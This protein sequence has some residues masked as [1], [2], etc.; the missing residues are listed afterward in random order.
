MERKFSIPQE[1]CRAISAAA[2]V[3]CSGSPER[4]KH[5]K[6][7]DWPRGVMLGWTVSATTHR[8]GL[9]NPRHHVFD[10]W[11]PAQLGS[12]ALDLTRISLM[13]LPGTSKG[14]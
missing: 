5:T 2:G 4:I 7:Q 11:V 3:G 1:I 6:A 12:L 13:A 14:P 9:H 8:H 10:A